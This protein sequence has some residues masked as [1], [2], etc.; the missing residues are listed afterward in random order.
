[1]SGNRVKQLSVAD[2]E[3]LVP[4]AD[5]ALAVQCHMA[6]IHCLETQIATLSKTIQNRI[7][8]RPEFQA[9]LTV[10]GIG[11]VLALTI[12][13]ETGDIGRFEHVGNFASYCRCVKSAKLSNGKRKG[14]GNV[15]N[16]NPYLAWAFTEAAH[17]AVRY[18][19]KIQRFYQRKQ[20]KTKEVVAIKAVAHKLARACY[21]VMRDHVP[22]DVN[23]AFA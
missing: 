15:K 4:E 22:F 8:L 7:K 20:A 5:V 23:K 9:L 3:H 2:L 11:Q 10:S 14:Q 6:V 19:P 18:H 21:Y 1:M 13:L 12:M 17:F 16:G